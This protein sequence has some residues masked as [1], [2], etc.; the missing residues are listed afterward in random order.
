MEIGGISEEG[1]GIRI[2]HII[3]YYTPYRHKGS[4]VCVTFGLCRGAVITAMVGV[5]FLLRSQA[6]VIFDSPPKLHLPPFDSTF[7]MTMETPTVRTPPVQREA[8]A[9][10]VV[11]QASTL[12]G[13]NE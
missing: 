10:P 9:T 8:A 12:S 11:L 13:Q 2:T 3:R 4:I 5:P 7:K 6:H 1:E